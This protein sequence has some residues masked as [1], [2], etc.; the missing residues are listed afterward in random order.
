MSGLKKFY[1]DTR[2]WVLLRDAAMGRPRDP[3]QIE[4]LYLLRR[5]VREGVAICPV[6]DAAWMEL[7]KQTD[8]ETYRATADLLDELSQGIA[9]L[10][11]Q[12][13]VVAEIRQFL[14]Q[15]LEA[16]T[17]P[18]LRH[19]VWVKAGYVLGLLVPTSDQLS[20][21]Q[22]RLIQKS[23]I[24]LFWSTT[25]RQI[26]DESGPLPPMPD[27]FAGSAERINEAMARYSHQIRSIQQAFA[28]E[29]AGILSVFAEDI[30]GIVLQH[31]R[32]TTGDP[33]PVPQSQATETGRK[34]LTALTNALRLKPKL[35]AARVPTVYAYAMCH[36]AVRMDKR[37]KFDGH[38]LVDIH[39]AACG[40]P[41]HDA[42]F[43]ETP[44]RV[45]VTAG[46]VA[47]DRTFNCTVM[48]RDDEIIEFLRKTV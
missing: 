31:Y 8:R 7:S 43:T 15:P 17:S 22:N 37:R 24:D 33:T 42:V 6:S 11:E 48:S 29:S 18:V 12:Q 4:I 26:A 39:H 44:L 32:D 14:T 45:L 16:S 35:M 34:A 21:E 2:Y 28:A 13:R 3:A 10:S 25:H 20:P 5:L 19:R 47:L 1:L 9:I 41:Y 46:N 40:I 36:A 38:D 30:T 27:G 23:S